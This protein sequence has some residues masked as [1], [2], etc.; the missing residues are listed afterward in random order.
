MLVRFGLSTWID[1]EAETAEEA[2]GVGGLP[3]P[4]TLLTLP[5]FP[6]SVGR[7]GGAIA[8]KDQGLGRFLHS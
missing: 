1:A 5:Q 4:A 2:H 7:G 3:I 8:G 6:R